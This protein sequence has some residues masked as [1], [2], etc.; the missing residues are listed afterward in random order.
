MNPLFFSRSLETISV[1]FPLH[2]NRDFSLHYPPKFPL[3][4]GLL[5]KIFQFLCQKSLL[6]AFS[7]NRPWLYSLSPHSTSWISI[8]F[9][10]S[11]V[12]CIKY[13]SFLV[14]SKLLTLSSFLAKCQ[15]FTFLSKIL[16]NSMICFLLM[17]QSIPI[18]LSSL[19]WQKH[20]T[21]IWIL[22][23]GL[24]PT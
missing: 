7:I 5:W 11:T 19:R 16:R 13:I 12:V 1:F 23:M 21:I 20:I 22:S 10:W 14:F 15:I 17:Y 6:A 8:L 4:T 3:K 9:W 24:K 2:R 18:L